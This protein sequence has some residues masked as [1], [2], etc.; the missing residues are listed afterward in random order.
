MN[1]Y[2]TNLTIPAGTTEASQVKTIIKLERGTIHQLEIGFPP[3]CAALAHVAISDRLRQFSPNNEGE[4]WAW[5]DYNL[6]YD[7]SY[8]LDDI[9]FEVVISGWNED[10]RNQ[11]IITVRLMVDSKIRVEVGNLGDLLFRQ[12]P[13]Q[14]GRAISAAGQGVADRIASISTSGRLAR[15]IAIIDRLARKNGR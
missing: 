10:V 8:K 1:A 12:V 11:H 4:Y 15:N 14:I 13:S 6:V 5:D 7:P 2:K 9:P 3:G